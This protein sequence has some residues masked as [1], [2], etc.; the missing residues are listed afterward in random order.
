MTATI[1]APGPGGPAA[2]E[3]P[4]TEGRLAHQPALDGIRALAVVAV[5]LY[6]DSVSR[7]RSQ[8]VPGG[9]LG[10]D[11]FLVL[12]GFLITGIL[13][14]NR[15][16]AGRTATKDFW[17]RRGRRLLPALLLMLL[18]AAAYGA[19]AS[20][21]WELHSLWTQSLATLLYVENWFTIFGRIGRAPIAHTWSLSVEEQWYFV[22]PFLLAGVLAITRGR[23]R[24][25][26]A[27]IGALTIASALL[28]AFEY[29]WHDW[30]YGY[31]STFTR[32][33]ELLIGCL[34]AVVLRDA[35]AI[36][37]RVGR[38]AAELAAF[39]GL[40]YLAWEF[41]RATPFDRFM[42][43]G[44]FY[45]AAL[46]TAAII[47]AV[48]QPSSLLRRAFAWRPIAAI[49][50]VSYGVYLYHVPLFRWMS[51]EATGL[52]TVPLLVARIAVLAVMAVASYRLVEMPIRNGRLRGREG[53]AAI[54]A[55]AVTVGIL[56]AVTRGSTAQPDWVFPRDR[57][58]TAAEA[59]P[60]GTQ[61]ILVAGELDA[62]DLGA[63]T[64][65]LVYRDVPRVQATSVASL[66]CNLIGSQAVIGE[67]YGPPS[68]C[69]PWQE[70]LPPLTAAFR[71]HVT[72][73][74]AGSGEVFDQFAG[75]RI[76][77]VGS[78]EYAGA[79]RRRL[80]EARRILQRSDTPLV[81]TTIPCIAGVEGDTSGLGAIQR[82]P[83]RLY[84]L[85]QVWVR[86]A[87]AHPKDVR[88]LDITPV[89]CPNGNARPMIDGEPVRD[90]NG[91]LTEAGAK[92][93]W[94]YLIDRSLAITRPAPSRAG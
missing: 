50:L 48:L 82:D 16:R 40:A 92:A 19:I 58:L 89:L 4:P 46:A 55:I 49:G 43:D 74:M 60:A 65:H 1:D 44:G 61:R 64:H 10:V 67:S 2:P 68:D 12:S 76:L 80:D 47:L 85:N 13:L 9:F 73:L 34:L 66:G 35:P 24:P 62:F 83:A 21:T 37:S 79:L 87:A 31:Y 91:R 59:T 5:V 27:T 71:P 84:W 86:Y 25:L 17:I 14:T 22:W 32:A 18:F 15:E 3:A 26:I 56:F 38:V 54:V 30:S 94:A 6:H 88:L 77:R 8:W 78:P 81:L 53:R 29:R 45:L 90:P 41:R 39:A 7:P 69:T 33:G 36:R 23:R 51:P 75:G 72:V 63:Q 52:G 93:L 42:Y 11:V 20:P 28:M 57:L 70:L